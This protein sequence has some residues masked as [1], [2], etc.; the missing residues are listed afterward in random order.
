MRVVHQF[1]PPPSDLTS[2]QRRAQVAFAK[3]NSRCHRCG[4]AGHW[5]G[6]RECPMR[7]RPKTSSEP[8]P[9]PRAPIQN[10]M[11]SEK[12]KFRSNV[13]FYEGSSSEEDEILVAHDMSA[14]RDAVPVSAPIHARDAVPVSRD[15]RDAVPV[16]QSTAVARDVVSTF[17]DSKQEP[18]AHPATTPEQ[19]RESVPDSDDKG[20]IP[21]HW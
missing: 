10:R 17:R 15:A 6:D 21:S 7:S 20:A 11:P 12:K 8:A 4:Q 2:E 14:I 5:S 13:T 1:R 9:P 19:T 18:Y 3:K 16:S